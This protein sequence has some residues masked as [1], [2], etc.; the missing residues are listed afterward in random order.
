LTKHSSSISNTSL[1]VSQHLQS[2]SVESV[3]VKLHTFNSGNGNNKCLALNYDWFTV[4]RWGCWYPLDWRVGL[5]LDWSVGLIVDW[6]V[7]L[8]LVWRVG[9][10]ADWRV[11]LI[12]EWRVGLIMDWMVGLI[13]DWRVGLILDWRVGI[14]LDWRVGIIFDLV[15]KKKIVFFL[16]IEHRSFSQPLYRMGNI[17]HKK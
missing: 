17:G 15:T 5:I 10:I 1:P 8:I 13:V 16:R 12:V 9:L 7:G 3:E 6:R 4:V 14:I 2:R 11:G